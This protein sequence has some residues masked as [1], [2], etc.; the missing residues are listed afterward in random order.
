MQVYVS[1]PFSHQMVR[2]YEFHDLFVHGLFRCGKSLE[3][4]KYLRPVFEIP[5][6]ISPMMNR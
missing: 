4:R 2:L 1:Q 5:A 6:G 3:Q